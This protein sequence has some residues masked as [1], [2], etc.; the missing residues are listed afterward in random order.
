MKKIILF[1]F[2]LLLTKTIKDS[3]NYGNDEIDFDSI[4]KDK[5][6]CCVV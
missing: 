3:L 4:C 1:V 5:K 6:N 2:A